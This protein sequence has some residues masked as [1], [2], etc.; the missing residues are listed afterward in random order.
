MGKYISPEKMTVEQIQANI[1]ER[2]EKW[3]HIAQNGCSD[4]GWPDGVN[5]NL[6]RNHIIYYYGLLHERQAGQ[7]QLSLFDQP[8]S[9]R[10]RPVPPKVPDNYMVAGCEHSHRLDGFGWDEK[11]VWGEKG[12]YK[13]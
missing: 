8:A 11:L 1:D 10:E 13:A 3:N 4:P 5:L 6:V 7:V 9:V 12:E 2:F